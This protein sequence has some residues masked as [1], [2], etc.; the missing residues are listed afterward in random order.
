M[1]QAQGS[2]QNTGVALENRDL[3]SRSHTA[4]WDT[5]WGW[6]WLEALWQSVSLWKVTAGKFKTLWVTCQ[7]LKNENKQIK[8]GWFLYGNTASLPAPH[9]TFQ[10]STRYLFLLNNV[11]RNIEPF[12]LKESFYFKQCLKYLKFY[13]SLFFHIKNKKIFYPKRLSSSRKFKKIHFVQS[14]KVYFFTVCICHETKKLIIY[15][16]LMLTSGRALE[17]CTNSSKWPDL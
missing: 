12:S 11:K 16:A 10:H 7:I 15:T 2:T 1:E 13:W 9:L 6:S 14:E 3:D 5:C 4:C 17:Q 8:I